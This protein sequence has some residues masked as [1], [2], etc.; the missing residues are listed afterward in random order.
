MRVAIIGGGVMGLSTAYYLA[1]MGA[2][3]TVF[4]QKYLLYGA[5]GRNSGGITPMIDKK[6]LIPFAVK[7]L[8]LYDTL[9]AE[10]DFNFLFRKDGYIKVAASEEDA[11]KLKKDVRMQNELGVRSKIIEPDE[12]RE[13]VPDFNTSA[14]TLAS[15]C[16]DSGVIFPWP[17]V[18]GLAKG[19]RELGVKILDQTRVEEVVVEGGVKGVKTNGEL[20]KADVVVNAAGA[21][22]NEISKMAGAK[23]NNRVVKEEICVTESIKPYLDPYIFDV[24]YGV[25]LSQSARGEI[26]GGIVG[27]EVE[28]IDTRSSLEFAVRYAKRATQ[29]IPMLKGLAMLRQWAGVYDEGRDGLPVV[30]FT[31]VEGFVQ[32]N[33]LGRHTGMIVAPA[34]GRELAKLI[35]KGENPNLKPFSPSRPTIA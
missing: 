14:I 18:W 7:S 31:E 3:V 21:W 5:S 1:K 27:S 11:E 19:C 4:E 30:G 32:A 6:E 34:M 33:G 15:Y 12:V 22:S 9:P 23:L 24:T 29:L 28:E 13:F 16:E 2:D 25:Y 17:V 35:I 10:V 8:E 26:V 20:H